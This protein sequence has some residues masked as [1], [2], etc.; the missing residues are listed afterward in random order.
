MTRPFALLLVS[1]FL[2]QYISSKFK[3]CVKIASL[4]SEMNCIEERKKINQLDQ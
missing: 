4:N 2:I 3:I 1:K